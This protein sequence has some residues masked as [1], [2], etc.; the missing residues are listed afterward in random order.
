LT[1]NVFAASDLA[2]RI[3]VN[4]ILERINGEGEAAFDRWLII[5]DA[6]ATDRNDI[7][8]LFRLQRLLFL[9]L[10]HDCLSQDDAS[11]ALLGEV[12]DISW[13]SGAQRRQPVLKL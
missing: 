8:F 4:V 1:P 3:A 9:S 6:G 5:F 10:V 11:C 13:L 12:A 7:N 2:E